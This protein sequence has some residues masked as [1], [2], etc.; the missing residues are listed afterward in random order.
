MYNLRL[1]SLNLKDSSLED[2]L[3]ADKA[4]R[5]EVETL[6]KVNQEMIEMLF[7][8]NTPNPKPTGTSSRSV[9]ALQNQKDGVLDPKK[10]Q[11]IA[12]LLR[13]VNKT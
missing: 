4:L 10:S 8:V 11:N 9:L 6:G 3:F 5:A 1:Q 7:V 13:A 12:L 2:K